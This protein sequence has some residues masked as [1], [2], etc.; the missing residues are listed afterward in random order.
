[1][2]KILQSIFKF[3]NFL[4]LFQMLF[5]WLNKTPPKWDPPLSVQ[6]GFNISFLKYYFL[7]LL[8]TI[9]YQ[10]IKF[11]ENT[12]FWN[13]WWWCGPF[14]LGSFSLPL[15]HELPK[16]ESLEPSKCFLPPLVINEWVKIIPKTKSDPFTLGSYSRPQRQGLFLWCS[17]F[18]PRMESSLERRRRMSYVVEA[19][20]FAE[21]S[22]S[23]SI[24]LWL[25]L[26]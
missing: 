8:N 18:L 22:N 11:F 24:Y 5:L 16:T 9:G 2:N 25:G 12:K 1:M 17:A 13:W 4:P 14:A 3:W 20:V 7:P 10:M 21:D 26:K 15:W 23:L 19:F 6:E